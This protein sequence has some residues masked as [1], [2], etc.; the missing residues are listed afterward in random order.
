MDEA[1]R[2]ELEELKKQIDPKV[3]ERV[4]NAMGGGGGSTSSAPPAQ[5][6]APLSHPARSSGSRG[7]GFGNLK[8]S[9]SRPEHELDLNSDQDTAGSAA[10]D[11]EFVKPEKQKND[12]AFIIFDVNMLRGRQIL[13][14]FQ[15]MNFFN[16]N[17]V[18]NPNRFIESLLN[19]LND[20]EITFP[21]VVAHSA[22]YPVVNAILSSDEVTNILNEIR[23]GV[24]IPIF[25]IYEDDRDL[26]KIH[27]IDPRYMISQRHEPSFSRKRLEQVLELLHKPC[28]SGDEPDKETPASP[29]E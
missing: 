17:M 3:L 24:K 2:R 18:G 8:D 1:K 10:A 11:S 6:S 16:S 20:A 13:A 15:R 28:G 12:K 5:S 27:D 26:A 25:I 22:V 14:Y 23:S 4:A 7:G 9:I 29:G 21:A 19:T